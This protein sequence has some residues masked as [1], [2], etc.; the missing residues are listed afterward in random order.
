M[1]GVVLLHGLANSRLIMTRLERRL[2]ADGYRT[3]N[4]SYPSCSAPIEA[5]ADRVNPELSKFAAALDGKLHFVTHSMGGVVAR[6]WIAR[7]RPKNLG[8]V[9]MIGPPNGGSE[10]ADLLHRTRVF[11]RIFGPAGQQMTTAEACARRDALGEPD[12]ALGVIAGAGTINPLASWFILPRPND[13]TVSVASTKV[14]GMAD[15][16]VVDASHS[17]LPLNGRVIEQVGHFLR[18]GRF[19][20]E[21]QAA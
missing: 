6:T 10:I 21:K 9:V 13:G 19:S 20:R 17:L 5:L 18:E 11:R 3:C 14:A 1:D 12:Y 4:L 16:I 15:H 2:R 7:A 8:R